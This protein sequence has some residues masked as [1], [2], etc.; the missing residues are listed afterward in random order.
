VIIEQ[1]DRASIVLAG[2]Y[3][4][5]DLTERCIVLCSKKLKNKHAN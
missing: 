1:R 4:N 2:S 3:L 5:F